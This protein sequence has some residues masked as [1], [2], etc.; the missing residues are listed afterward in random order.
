MK[1]ILLIIIT[2]LLFIPM[3]CNAN[4]NQNELIEVYLFYSS[5]CG[6][7]KAAKEFL[8]EYQSEK[9]T[10]HI[11]YYEV[12]R[13]KRNAKT[14][15]NVQEVLDHPSMN[16]PY[17]VI[18][19]EIIIGYGE[20]TDKE[21]VNVI[22]YYLDNDYINIPG[23]II[24]GEITKDNI[25]EYIKK[26]NVISDNKANI[27]LLGE[28]DVKNI[29]I[30]FLGIVMG[31][32]DGFNPCA[33][34]I[35]IFLISML[36]NMKDRKRMWILGIS[37]LLTSA[38]VY[39]LI[40]GAWLNIVV[41]FTQVRWI[42]IIIG[43]IALGGALFNFRSYYL[44]RKKDAGCQ[45]VDEKKRKKIISKIKKFTAEKSFILALLGIILLAASVNIV[46]LACSAGLPVLY[47]N[48]LALNH[49]TGI[50]SIFYIFIYI[51]FFLLDDLIIFII[52]AITF[53]VT[54]MTTKYTKFS[55]LIGAI[56]MLVIGILMIIKP[57]FVMFNF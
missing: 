23:K 46:E 52:A 15:E 36:I 51:L 10:I 27:P 18:G 24:D 14:F 37:F 45:V 42:Q 39:A 33:M 34:W 19:G 22:E 53:K 28:V 7:C 55:H 30:P 35:L 16:V 48:I 13:N 32:V 41:N 4:T 31:L 40:M 57:E 9:Q 25:S 1:K 56:I 43:L 47:T 11:N 50:A 38:L 2:I 3:V 44:E 49:I 29:S 20:N 17:I 12:T 26:E 6:H 54:G 21:I 5:S 8:K